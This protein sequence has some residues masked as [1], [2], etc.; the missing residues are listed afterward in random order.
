MNLGRDPAEVQALLVDCLAPIDAEDI[1]LEASEKIYHECRE[2][3]AH[4]SEIEE[5]K[6]SEIG[7]VSFVL[8]D[9]FDMLPVEPSNADLE[10]AHTWCLK[11]MRTEV[12]QHEEEVLND[13]YESE[14]SATL[15]EAN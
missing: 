15:K 7:F 4:E 3:L 6:N 2:M 9:C 8:D 11:K 13:K 1:D 5:Q 12:K 14:A 10:K